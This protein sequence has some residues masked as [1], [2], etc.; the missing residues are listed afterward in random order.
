MGGGIG[1]VVP[2][3]IC[4]KSSQTRHNATRAH[5]STSWGSPAHHQPATTS[6][7]PHQLATTTASGSAIRKNTSHHH[8]QRRAHLPR[9]QPHHAAGPQKGQEGPPSVS[10][11]EG[12]PPPLQ[13]PSEDEQGST[14]G[15]ARRASGTHPHKTRPKTGNWA[16]G[17]QSTSTPPSLCE[18]PAR[19]G[20]CWL[21]QVR[22]GCPGFSLWHQREI[23]GAGREGSGERR[24]SPPVLL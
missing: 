7:Q 5:F 14:G 19:P 15:L 12:H 9:L 2:V 22:V 23:R 3:L 16:S 6:H 17:L 10:P 24:C 20:R 21:S 18:V 1:G 4:N 11:R 13:Q 8:G